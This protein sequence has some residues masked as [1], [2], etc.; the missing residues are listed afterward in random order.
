M[1][2]EQATEKPDTMRPPGTK[3][4]PIEHTCRQV[5]K[6]N[7]SIIIGIPK[8][9]VDIAHINH[10]DKFNIYYEPLKKGHYRIILEH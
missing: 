10:K 8:I 4:R 9:I 2:Q 6:N 5:G 7:P 3:S 1:T